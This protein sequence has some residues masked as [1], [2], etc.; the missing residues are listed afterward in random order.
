MSDLAAALPLNV[1]SMPLA[2]AAEAVSLAH[3]SI[4][5]AAPPRLAICCIVRDSART[6][7][8]LLGS[9]VGCEGGPAADE[10]V[11]TDT[12]SVDDTRDRIAKAFGLDSATA[13]PASVGD[14]P[15]VHEIIRPTGVMDGGRPVK[16][17]TQHLSIVPPYRRVRVVLSRFEWI[18]D[19][20]AARQYGFDLA[21]ATWRAYFDS[22]D[23]VPWARHMRD[24]VEATEIRAPPV[25]ALSMTYDYDPALKQDVVRCVRW[26]DGWKWTRPIHEHL[27]RSVHGQTRCVS[28]VADFV[29]HHR[30]ADGHYQSSV[31]RNFGMLSVSI[32]EARARGDRTR[33]GLDAFSLGQHYRQLGDLQKAASYYAE[34]A[35]ALGATNIAAIA[36]AEYAEMAALTGQ[37]DQAVDIAA[38]AFGRAPELREGLG[39]LAIAHHLRHDTS[40]A[41]DLFDLYFSRPPPVA[42]TSH[43]VLFLDGVVPAHATMAYIAAGQ[44]DKAQ[45]ALER[46]SDTAVHDP[47]VKP[48]VKTAQRTLLQRRGVRILRE[49]HDFW[50]WSCEPIKF[51][52]ILRN[53]VP[54]SIAELPEVREIHGWVDKK[55]PHLENWEQYQKAYADI[56]T[57]TFHTNEALHDHVRNNLGRTKGVVAWAKALPKDGPPVYV[58]SIGAQDCIIERAVME[59]NERISMCAIDVSPTAAVGIQQL[60]ADYPG[61]VTTHAIVKH[62]YDWPKVV[63]GSEQPMDGASLGAAGRPMGLSEVVDPADGEVAG[64]R[65]IFGRRF[66]AVMLFE[67][68]EHVPDDLEA[69]DTIYDMLAPGGRFFLSTP[70]ASEWIEPYLTGPMPPWHFHGHVRGYSPT[71]LWRKL[72]QAGFSGNLKA[73]DNGSLFFASVTRPVIGL[74]PSRDFAGN[75]LS[76]VCPWTP[77][78][79][80]PQSLHEG[81]V[82]GSEEAV[83][84]L[85]PAL[86]ALG[87]EVTVYAGMPEREDRLFVHDSVR[88]RPSTEFNPADDHGTVLMWRSPQSLLVPGVKDAKWRKFSWL[89][90]LAHGAPP[91]AYEA[92]DKV[93]VLSETAVEEVMRLDKVPHEKLVIAQNG[94]DGRLFPPL[95]DDAGREPHTCIWA[96]SPNR[97]LQHLLAIWPEVRAAVPDATLEIFYD[98]TMFRHAWPTWA[99][100]LDEKVAALKDDGVKFIGGVSHDVLFAAYKRAGILGFP[101]T[102]SETFCLHPDTLVA[103]PGNHHTSAPASARIADLVGKSGFPVY[104]FDPDQDRFR[105]ATCKKVWETKRVTELVHI[106]LDDGAVLRITPEHL[107][108]NFEGEWQPA[109]SL[110]VGARLMAL[111]Y[112]YNVSIKDVDGYWVSESRLVGEWMKGRPLTKD[113]HVDHKDP[114]RLD[115]RPESL[116]VMTV[117]EHMSKTH[118]GQE[119]RRA[120][121]KARM[122]G[123]KVW[124]ATDEGRAAMK[125]RN[126]KAGQ[127]R[128]YKFRQLPLEERNRIMAMASVTRA[129][130]LAAKKAKQ[131]KVEPKFGYT[132]TGSVR[133]KP[134]GGNVSAAAHA[135][136]QRAWAKRVERYGPSGRPS[137]ENHKIVKIERVQY[138]DGLPVY[139]MEVEGLH[140]F[141]AEGV[142]VHN[143]TNAALS[144]AAGCW[145][146]VTAHGALR[147][148]VLTGDFVSAIQWDEG[149]DD[150]V[151][152][153]ENYAH[154]PDPEDAKDLLAAKRAEFHGRFAKALIHRL[155]NPPTTAERE[156]MRVKV[157]ERFDWSVSARIFAN[158][159]FGE[160]D[161]AA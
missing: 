10:F 28:K 116:E 109:E 145:P 110:A 127:T 24:T 45:V 76:I 4:D 104:S 153:T 138:P 69:L 118:R 131:E 74:T 142:V 59:Q 18:N 55:L 106:T 47:R 134:L 99:R 133:R 52:E 39:A 129:T 136:T 81:H 146:V 119:N 15:I 96:S 78:P 128:W 156:A 40:R 70:I 112:R 11:W 102:Y 87:V 48:L 6:I 94:I 124:L 22:D 150:K 111:H 115:N 13:W 157:I 73:T 14:A 37:A 159:M 35:D 33:V 46:I 50:N 147:T 8:A 123:L 27:V 2:P 79:F 113:E 77:I 75:R 20:S 64:Y 32:E 89:H 97:G 105:L 101:S 100:D 141:V 63:P 36:L 51:R 49:M 21:T 155:Q 60:I 114:T 25:N 122:E 80:D 3:P 31:D 16:I 72:R 7:D 34:C 30:P 144:Q 65:Q 137:G 151:K 1:T 126:V 86:A 93:I 56:P 160:K 92:C 26:A 95:G 149:T 85:A 125:T 66:D 140:N 38:K 143:C 58:A 42:H 41:V 121:H 154:Y 5:P 68:I 152:A 98:W 84:R 9:I 117:A 67:V 29:V 62:H 82:G 158:I 83:I 161:G 61:R 17:G 108:M 19:F 103:L 53:L 12:G 91:E 148:T 54:E 130:N 139:D 135:G 132:A 43:D 23:V 44:L 107:M 71:S 90:D 120:A 57:D 88:W